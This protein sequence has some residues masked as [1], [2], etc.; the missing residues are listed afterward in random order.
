MKPIKSQNRSVPGYEI[1]Q[2]E[3]DKLVPASIYQEIP[4][5]NQ[6]ESELQQGILKQPLI[7]F[8]CDLKHWQGN[9][10]RLYGAHSPDLP[11]DNPPI[12]DDK[13]HIV[14]FGRQRFQLLKEMDY[15]HVDIVKS[16][17]FH[18]MI[19]LGHQIKH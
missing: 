6:L 15:T 2:I 17:V 9:H 19:R 18:E 5:R 1:Q 10:K 4:D 3:I 7:V 12:V 14:W 8:Q 13:V 11:W 16:T